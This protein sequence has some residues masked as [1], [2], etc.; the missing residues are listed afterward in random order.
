VLLMTLATARADVVLDWNAIM[1]N[2][3]GGQNPFAQARFA[4]ITQ[5]AVF[6]AVNAITGDYEPY[7]GTIAA[8]PGASAEAAAIAAAH[9]VLVNYFLGSAASLDTARANSLAAIPDGP[10]KD[11]GIAVGEAAAAAMI[12]HRA[13]DGSTPPQFYVPPSANPGEWQTTPGCPPA[14]GIFL[15][16]RN[17]TPFG[18]QSGDQFR[19]DPPPALT[20][21]RYRKDYNEVK[22]VG[23]LNS[24]KRPQDR[25]DV[26]RYFAVVG[27][28]HVW[29][30]AA[31]QVSAAEGK[32]LSKN[33]RAFALLNI[34]I[35]DALVSAFETKYY[36]VFWRPY[37]AI[38]AG[39]TDGNPKTDPDVL[40]M[41]FV[42]TPCFPSYP[43]AHASAGYAGRAIVERIFGA[44]GH[45]IT[46]SHPLI[47]DVILHYTKFSQMT[48]DIDDARVY[49]GIH[50]RFDQ[51]AGARQGRRVGT[52]VYKNHLRR[53]GN[54]HE[55]C[56]EL[57]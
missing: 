31:S 26:A 41:T 19:S 30:Q 46:L 5:T 27:A 16:W 11:N 9:G 35:S 15:H 33:A 1:L 12:T 36:Y 8:P 23:E 55:D 7:L 10:A 57:D 47:P 49:G 34:A 14:G 2:T 28:P 24:T 48:R 45:D 13:N 40:W 51:E 50:F 17:L 22:E 32:S 43:S 44:G 4:A 29:N 21:N 6:E 38:R 56:G 54:H 52:Y 20:S 39:D 37:T 25:T 3:I 18:I 42:P 53:C